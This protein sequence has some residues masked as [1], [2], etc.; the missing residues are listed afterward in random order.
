MQD[1][2]IWDWLM[3]KS[4]TYLQG[5]NLWILLKLLLQPVTSSHL[6]LTLS[7]KGMEEWEEW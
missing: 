6:P 1:K 4:K 3:L 2:I 7:D 5:I